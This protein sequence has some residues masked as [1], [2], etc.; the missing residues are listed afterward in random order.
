VNEKFL[1]G[2]I[3]GAIIWAIV[4][5]FFLIRNRYVFKAGMDI[6]EDKDETLPNKLAR[7]LSLP[8]Y[9]DMLFNPKYWLLWTT[10]HWKAW[11]NRQ[12]HVPTSAKGRTRA[13]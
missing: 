2:V 8:R 3:I 9:E 12:A 13:K 5:G 1:I 10:D 6:L 11:L 7:Y 4:T